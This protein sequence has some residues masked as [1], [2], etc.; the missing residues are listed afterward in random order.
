[1]A[2]G[3]LHQFHRASLSRFHQ[4]WLLF[5]YFAHSV[6]VFIIVDCIGRRHFR[7]RSKVMP[8]IL[9]A[10]SAGANHINIPT[11]RQTLARPVVR[12]PGGMIRVLL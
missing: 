5:Q 3:D 1:M 4:P 2:V 12:F 6:L 9:M 11:P 7:C 10:D 8:N